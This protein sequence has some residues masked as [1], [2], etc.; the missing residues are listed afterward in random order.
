MLGST[1][2]EDHTAMITLYHNRVEATE[3]AEQNEAEAIVRK[4]RAAGK[5]RFY[6]KPKGELL[7]HLEYEEFDTEMMVSSLSKRTE[8]FAYSIASALASEKKLYRLS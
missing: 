6:L 5:T 7:S 3:V 8:R 2:S 1:T 4:E